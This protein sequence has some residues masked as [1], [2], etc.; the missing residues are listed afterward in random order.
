MI[1]VGIVAFEILGYQVLVKLLP[2]LPKL[3]TREQL[4]ATATD[5]SLH[6]ALGQ[7]ALKH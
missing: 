3:H 5:E 4:A 7:K 1:T 2:V 6:H